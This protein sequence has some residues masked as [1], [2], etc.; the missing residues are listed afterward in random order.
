MTFKSL[1]CAL[2]L[3]TV[4]IGPAIAGPISI[5]IAPDSGNAPSPQMGQN[6]LFHSRIRNE[7]TGSIE[8]LIVWLSLIEVDPGNEQPVDLEDWSAKKAITVA[9]LE[10][11]AIVEAEWPLR[12]I[13]SGQYRVVLNVMSR[14]TSGIANSAFN[15]FTVREKPVVESQRV[16]P[17]ALG[18]P[19]ILSLILLWRWR[20]QH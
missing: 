18:A 20:R 10:P 3:T 17:I 13:Q 5:E 2:A 12:L 19:S 15:E 4:T 1:I 8:G 6:L 9:S 14:G 16:L 7:G 11:G